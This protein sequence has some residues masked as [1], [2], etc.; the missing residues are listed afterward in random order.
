MASA[1]PFLQEPPSLG[2]GRQCGL[3][4]AAEF[5]SQLRVRPWGG[6][7]RMRSGMAASTVEMD[8]R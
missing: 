1:W 4:P 7:P 8:L 2:S 3:P 6:N 5:L